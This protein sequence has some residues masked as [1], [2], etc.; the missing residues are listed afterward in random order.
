M[1]RL[2]VYDLDG[3]LI[4]SRRDIANAVNWTLQELDLGGLPIER[5]SAFVGNGVKNL[6]RQALEEV[7]AGPRA[8]PE[9]G[10]S[11]GVRQPRGV[12]PTVLERSIKLFRRRYEEHLLEDTHLYPSVRKVLEFFKARLQAVMTNKPED[13][14]LKIL[15]GLGIDFYF[16]RVLGGDRGFPKKPAPEP[17]F[18]ILRSAGVSSEEALLVGDSATDVETGRNAGVKTVAVTYGFGS[19]SEIEKSKPYAILNDLTE[20]I[21]CPL[22]KT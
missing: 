9:N 12:A 16:F 13:F 14:S 4:D 5:V 15:R 11:Q 6:M 18:E 10:S 2:I 22:L 19:R 17:L 8:C 1:I 20:L 21:E 3:T 7:G